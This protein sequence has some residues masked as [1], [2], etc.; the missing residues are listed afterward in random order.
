M[1][2]G[3]E[4]QDSGFQSLSGEYGSLEHFLQV[5]EVGAGCNLPWWVGDHVQELEQRKGAG[6]IGGLLEEGSN[7]LEGS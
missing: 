3:S 1:P 2:K 4:L 6:D 5:F 7:M